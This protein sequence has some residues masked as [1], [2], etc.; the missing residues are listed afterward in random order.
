MNE[1]NHS[2]AGPRGL[3]ATTAALSLL[4]IT[5]LYADGWA[6]LNVGG[7]ETFFTPWHAMLYGSFALLTAW[8][9]WV[10][11]RRRRASAPGSRRSMRGIDGAW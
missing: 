11:W 4:V 6:H 7:L 9:A 8:I 5:G 1:A 10:T 3:D 2:P